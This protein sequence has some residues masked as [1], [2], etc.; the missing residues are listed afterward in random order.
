MCD[1]FEQLW[2]ELRNTQP[3]KETSIEL[4]KKFKEL[5]AARKEENQTAKEKSIAW[6]MLE[7]MRSHKRF[8]DWSKE[9][10][11]ELLREG[12]RSPVFGDKQQCKIRDW[13]QRGNWVL[14]RDDG[15]GDG[16]YFLYDG[17]D[18]PDRYLGGGEFDIDPGYNL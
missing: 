17:P 8:T 13:L 18:D 10:V 4:I 11:M 15:D 1:T 9:G 12:E 16:G 5:L 2:K 6:N 14:Q 3:E 7:Y